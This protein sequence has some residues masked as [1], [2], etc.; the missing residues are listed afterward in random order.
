MHEAARQA[1]RLHPEAAREAVEDGTKLLNAGRV[2]EAVVRFRESIRLAPGEPLAYEQLCRALGNKFDEVE[3]VAA[4]GLQ[5]IKD[6][7]ALWNWLAWARM[8]QGKH[9]QAL[10]AYEELLR[11]QPDFTWV[12]SARAELLRLLKRTDEAVKTAK[13]AIELLPKDPSPRKVLAAIEADRNDLDAAVDRYLEA[14]EVANSRYWQAHSELAEV[15][16][17]LEPDKA[18]KVLARREFGEPLE[19]GFTVGARWLLDGK[20][21]EYRKL[22]AQFRDRFESMRS[23]RDMH[24]FSRLASLDSK[25]E[26]P[27]VRLVRQAE[28]SVGEFNRAPFVLHTLALAQL[29]AGQTEEAMATA[30]EALKNYPAWA[31]NLN[32]L[33]LI[34]ADHQRGKTDEAGKALEALPRTGGDGS[35]HPHDALAY[36][37]LLRE[38]EDAVLKK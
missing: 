11:V 38:A 14:I 34:L 30:N 7:P 26:V 18:R 36:R 37:V 35:I 9:E 24:L 3:K 22:V 32:K 25:P 33:V 6:W 4:E 20:A 16:L 15:L 10:Q 28:L 29:R 5:Q 2:E 27:P 21:D 12:H 19:A 31:P 17:R 8:Q 1:M 23:G 13:K